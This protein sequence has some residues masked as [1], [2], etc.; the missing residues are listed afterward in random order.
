MAGPHHLELARTLRNSAGRPW[1]AGEPT[2][3]E[4]WQERAPISASARFLFHLEVELC[5]A[6]Q[7]KLRGLAPP[8][9]LSHEEEAEIGQ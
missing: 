1:G 3:D 7:R 5:A 6:E 2:P 4:R 9:A 8:A